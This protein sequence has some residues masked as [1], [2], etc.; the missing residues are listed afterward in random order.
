[1]NKF[2]YSYFYDFFKRKDEKDLKSKNLHSIHFGRLKSY[3]PKWKLYK[4][5]LYE[6]MLFC[7]KKHGQ[8]FTKITSMIKE[9]TR[10]GKTSVY[11]YIQELEEHGFIT[12]Y[13]SKKR[14]GKDFMNRYKINFDV[15]VERLDEI[16]NLPNDED[17][18]ANIE[19]LKDMYEYLRDNTY[20]ST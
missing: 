12:V 16:Y 18:K 6:Y 10:L 20:K 5:I 15:I 3:N 13:R 4:I 2:E 1:M 17:K 8:E 11:K 9:A 19:F 7:Y 14:N